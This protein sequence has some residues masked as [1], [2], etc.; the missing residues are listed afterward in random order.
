MLINYIHKSG[1]KRCRATFQRARLLGGKSR[2]FVWRSANVDFA[3]TYV[4]AQRDKYRGCEETGNSRNLWSRIDPLYS[5]FSNGSAS[6][7]SPLCCSES[8]IL[9]RAF[10]HSLP[11]S[12]LFLPLLHCLYL[13]S[14]LLE[15]ND[16]AMCCTIDGKIDLLTSSLINIKNLLVRFNYFFLFFW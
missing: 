9:P 4:F 7:S 3:M 12:L 14:L 2:E 15:S 8:A 16:P 6:A 5:L 10:L 11:S 1:T 13:S